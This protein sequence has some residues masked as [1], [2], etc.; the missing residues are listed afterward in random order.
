[1]VWTLPARAS[2]WSRSWRAPPLPRVPIS[3]SPDPAQPTRALQLSGED[4]P[5]ET[6]V[7]LLVI[8]PN[9]VMALGDSY[10]ADDGCIDASVPDTGPITPGRYVVEV[11]TV[12]PEGITGDLLARA[13][14]TIAE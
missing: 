6:E 7:R 11:L 8:A 14:L 13:T 10:I 5:P 1:M 12:L 2:S 9:R 4:L 3:I